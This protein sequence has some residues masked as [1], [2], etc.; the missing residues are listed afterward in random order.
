[1]MRQRVAPSDMVDDQS[2]L[3]QFMAHPHAVQLS[4]LGLTVT[5]RKEDESNGLLKCIRR[6]D[7]VSSA[8]SRSIQRLRQNNPRPSPHT[9]RP[10]KIRTQTRGKG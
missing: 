7:Q 1:M 4:F 9:I 6:A 5:D 8:S 10:P 2:V 3:A